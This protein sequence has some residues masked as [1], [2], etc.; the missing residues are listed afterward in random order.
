MFEVWQANI[1]ANRGFVARDQGP[2]LVSVVS[3]DEISQRFWHQRF[4][5]TRSDVFR[6]DGSTRVVS[7]REE[8]RKGN[9]LGTLRAW[10]QTQSMVA[11]ASHSLPQIALMSM[12]FGQGRRLSPFTQAMGNRKP[13]FL[14]PMKG[15]N[16][17]LYL[18]AA[19][20]SNLYT[21]LWIAHLA[22]SG[23]RGLLVKWGDEAIVPGL[24][25]NQRGDDFSGVD[26][27]RFVWKT[28]I[29]DELAREKDWV[30][31]DADTGLMSFQYARQPE[32]SLRRRL[33]ELPSRSYQFGVNLGSLAVS[34]EL[35]DAAVEVFRQD[36]DDPQR[37]V[38]WDP[39]VWI[40]LS[41]RSDDDWRREVQYEEQLGGRGIRELEQRIPDF[42]PKIAKLRE[43]HEKRAGRPLAVGVLDFGPAFWTDVGLN[44]R[45]RECLESLTKDSDAGRA[46]REL[47]GIPHRRDARGNIILRSRLPETMDLEQ[48]LVMD[49]LITD[50][51]GPVR[52]GV[53]VGCRL[54]QVAMPHGGN[55]IFCAADRLR[56]DGPDGIAYRSVGSEIVVPKGGRHTTLFLPEGVRHM[57]SN[58][59]VLDYGGRNYT[60]P[61]EGNTLSF[62][63]AGRRMA[64]ADGAELEA[65]W[66]Q[67]WENQVTP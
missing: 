41:C 50:Q 55:A 49:S 34:Y 37:W 46:Y 2:T 13:A 64:A 61:I 31:I 24:N 39:Y 30:A 35:L 16:T 47:F 5:S 42:Y 3:G 29:T 44:R 7:V 27:V 20:M 66:R 67:A 17:G 15:A 12:V 9:F 45:L 10:T 4:A 43:T 32:A 58:E 14:L 21:N 62:E 33:A 38:D 25:W 52:G 18:C 53:I 8:T 51:G 54:G 63:E 22:A 1:A 59:R 40:A 57:T 23:F 28:Q 48:S 19:E 11:E 60:G 65:R 56:F 6:K 36:L 26:A